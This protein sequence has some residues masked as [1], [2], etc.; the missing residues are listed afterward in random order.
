M[1]AKELIKVGGRSVAFDR[2][3]HIV[4]RYTNS[5]DAAFAYPAYD[6]YPR[7]GRAQV[8]HT[9]L[10]APILLNVRHLSLR[11]YYGLE[12]N[13]DF[14]NAR[15]RA[16]DEVPSLDRAEPVEYEPLIELLAM[17]DDPARQVTGV[18]LTVLTK[19]QHRMRPDLI[20]LYDRNIKACYVGQGEDH[21]AP[22]K[23]RSWEAFARVW[24]LHVKGDLSRQ[25]G[26]WNLLADLAPD[27]VSISPLRALD[28]VG[29]NLG[30]QAAAE[31]AD[32]GSV[33]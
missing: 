20:P 18:K 1:P 10:L 26:Q 28:F 15:L 8:T 19:V 32:G 13:L 12:A 22:S 23:G 21:I 29:W 16:L 24:I 25:I 2:A 11:S 3:V 14:I 5:P 31:G 9:D 30:A 17:L 27:R 6:S 4:R 7:A 33:G